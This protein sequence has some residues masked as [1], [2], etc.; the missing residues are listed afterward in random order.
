MGLPVSNAKL[1]MWLFLAT[2]VMFFMG[3]IGSYIVLRGGAPGWPDPAWQ[4]AN[5]VNLL[6]IPVGALNTFVLICSS[7]TMVL[8]L[9]ATEKAQRQQQQLFLALT[10]ALGSTFMI[11]KAFEYTHKI[12]HGYFPGMVQ[13][14][15]LPGGNLFPSCYFTLTGFHGL[16]VLGGIVML[17]MLLVWSLIGRLGPERYER[18]ELIGLYWH[19]VDLVWIFLFPLLYLL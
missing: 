7:V 18:V 14:H 1:A 8:A 15:P 9:S 19:F 2:E 5:Q 16:H 17:A 12:E 10:I 11:V 3:L 6:S 13:S 4:A